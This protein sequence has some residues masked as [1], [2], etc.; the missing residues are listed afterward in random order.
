MEWIVLKLYVL[1]YKSSS[2]VD[3]RW[4]NSHIRQSHQFILCSNK[5][6]REGEESGG[7]IDV[8]AN[9]VSHELTVH[10]V[11]ACKPAS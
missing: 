5:L 2:Y 9:T 6:A 4:Q 3:V 1:K 11:C 10:V 8:Q 7:V